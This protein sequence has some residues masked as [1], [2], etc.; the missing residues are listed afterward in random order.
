M[1]RLAWTLGIL[2]GNL[3]QLYL[4]LNNP[5][6]GAFGSLF[7]VPTNHKAFVDLSLQT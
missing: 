4:D 6:C 5:I 1:Q 3:Y 2:P 7:S